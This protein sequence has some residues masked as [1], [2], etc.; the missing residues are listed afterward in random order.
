M[1]KEKDELVREHYKSESQSLNGFLNS[2]MKDEVVRDREVEL[3]LKFFE[4]MVDKKDKRVLDL[5][6]GNG[7]SLNIVARN[8]PGLK[9]YGIEYTDELLTIAQSIPLLNCYVAKGDARKL[10]FKDNYFDVVYTVRCL[11]NI[12][13]WEDQ[14]KALQEIYRTLK[15]NGCYLM[16]E[17]FTDGQLNYS[18]ARKECGLDE[19][20]PAYHN[21]YI[22]K[23]LFMEVIKG[24]FSLVEPYWLQHNFLSSHYFI[25]RV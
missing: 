1:S 14:K 9:F 13:S 2:T 7:Y 3:L 24:K 17:C 10:L 4:T 8:F 15:P 22:D 23:D 5:G 11:I 6:C 18:R 12:L 25:S 16:I 19:I 21:L 20:P